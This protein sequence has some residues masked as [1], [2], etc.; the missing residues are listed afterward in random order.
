MLK[1]LFT[2]IKNF[3][4]ILTLFLFCVLIFVKNKVYKIKSDI[5]DVNNK[6]VLLDKESEVVELELTYLSRP[7]RL[8]NIYTKIKQIDIPMN[9]DG[10]IL[11]TR[12]QIKDIRGLIPYYYTKIE[13][14]KNSIAQK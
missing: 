7:E 2:T 8:K 12:K 9:L 6:I 1:D 10:D 11:I 14:N 3:L 13:N 5:R 4:F